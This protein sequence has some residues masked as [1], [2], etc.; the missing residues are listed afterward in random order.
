MGGIWAQVN[1]SHI[2]DEEAK[3]KKSPFRI[4]DLKPIQ[5]ATFD[6]EEYQAGGRAFTTDQWIDLLIRSMGME[7]I[8][9]DRRLK[10]LF[11]TRLIPLCEQN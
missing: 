4:D 9:F 6:L 11:L 1:L 8:H 5:V 10:L 2:Y 7:P 3:G